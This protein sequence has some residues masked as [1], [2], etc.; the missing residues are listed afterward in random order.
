MTR[1]EAE[2][3]LRRAGALDDDAIDLAGTALVLASFEQPRVDLARYQAHLAE[4]EAQVAD[5][6]VHSGASA[7]TVLEPALA[8]RL[9]ALNE[10]LFAR[11]DYA[12]DE[13]TY[14]VV[15][16]ANLMR[17]I[18]RRRG[19]P[20]AL[21]ILYI[22]AARAQGWEIEGLS[23]PGHFLVRLRH[24]GAG[25]IVDPFRRGEVRESADLRRMLKLAAGEEAELT[26]EH[27]APV[28][29]RAILLRLQN[30]IKLRLLQS[31]KHEPA[32]AV[33]GRMLLLAPEEASLW[34]ELGIVQAQ[35]G[36]LGAAIGALERFTELASDDLARHR[37]AKLIQELKGKL[38]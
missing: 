24:G 20:V 14:D 29:N 34:R 11:H 31:D 1:E 9:E 28:G 12:G 7:F 25:V 3:E 35:L 10:V 6:V 8:Q 37:A 38:N 27:Y 13:L 4:L 5:L 32:A 17:V 33:I 36:N 30:N 19:L 2:E 23:F 22:H 26:P 16:N 21:S 15:R 18:D